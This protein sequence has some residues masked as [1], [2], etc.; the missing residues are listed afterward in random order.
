MK[1]T[2]EFRNQYS[3]LGI[4]KRITESINC[5]FSANCKVLRMNMKNGANISEGILSVNID[6]SDY[7]KIVI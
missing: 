3:K 5:A 2:Q 7:L 6:N 4:H 1:Q